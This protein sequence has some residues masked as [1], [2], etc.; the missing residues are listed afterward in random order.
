[1]IIGIL[2]SPARSAA[3]KSPPIAEPPIPQRTIERTSEYAGGIVA[4][5]PISYASRT[6]FARSLI[7]SSML[8]R[9]AAR[10]DSTVSITAPS[11]WVSREGTLATIHHPLPGVEHGLDLVLRACLGVYA[12]ERLGTRE[13]HEQPR[14][15]VDEELHA[16]FGVE[17]DRVL[18]G[19][20]GQL[21][22]ALGIK[23]LHDL[24]LLL[25]VG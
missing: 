4:F 17:E 5:R 3:A 13:T 14:P 15:V 8:S 19:V 22:R 24:D 23:A 2:S 11:T 18:H 20:A 6:C 25:C 12:D 9:S 16:V 21:A 10:I 7:R 1:M